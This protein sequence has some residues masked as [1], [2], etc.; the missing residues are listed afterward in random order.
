MN[1]IGWQVGA[2]LVGISTLVIAVYVAKLLNS[3]NEIVKKAGRMVDYNERYI[4]ET[5][6]N[7]TFIA[8]DVRDILEVVSKFSNL[9]KV[10][11][12]FRK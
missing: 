10:F 4:N 9:L 7:V 5:I 3:T 2:V 1:A 6:E 12:I 8:K 11:K